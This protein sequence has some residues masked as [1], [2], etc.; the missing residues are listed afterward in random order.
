MRS[1]RSAVALLALLSA[2]SRYAVI[3]HTRTDERVAEQH[4]VSNGARISTRVISRDAKSV[5]LAVEEVPVCRNA[6]SGTRRDVGVVQ[7]TK[8]AMDPSYALFAVI[9]GALV[10]GS[11]ALMAKLDTR[12]EECGIEQDLSWSCTEHY[13]PVFGIGIGGLV[14][15]ALGFLPMTAHVLRENQTIEESPTP[16]GAL[17]RWGGAARPCPDAEAKP[18]A[19]TKVRIRTKFGG[20]EM[21]TV[22][23]TGPDGKVTVPTAPELV[24][25]MC[26]DGMMEIS[27]GDYAAPDDSPEKPDLARRFA[28][29]IKVV[30][31]PGP[32]P[33]WA[34]L[35]AAGDIELAAA[36]SCCVN[37]NRD[38][39]TS[40]CT[41]QCAEAGDVGR[42]LDAFETCVAKAKAS[43][44][45]KFGEAYCQQLFE[46]CLKVNDSSVENL[47]RC[48]Y[49]CAGA[50]AGDACR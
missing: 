41:K 50:K 28:E 31:K 27:A 29:A 22:A 49:R 40:S 4:D 2:C 18:L 44:D 7:R 8:R 15:G 3:E 14:A 32:K 20:G 25:G 13:T 43:E 39:Y 9:G 37:E 6:V 36:R 19:N 46:E 10:V 47:V 30:I 48:T 1:C 5:V 11:L 38:R 45:P 42:C 26:G 24:A 21:V 16:W 34:E 35:A 12:V 17:S 33:T 23:F